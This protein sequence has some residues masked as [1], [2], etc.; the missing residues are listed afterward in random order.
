M[1]QVGFAILLKITLAG[2]TL[3]NNSQPIVILLPEF[4]LLEL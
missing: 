4:I 1:F 3:V 2:P